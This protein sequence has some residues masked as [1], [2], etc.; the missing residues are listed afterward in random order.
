MRGRRWRSWGRGW[1]SGEGEDFGDLEPV[2]TFAW[3]WGFP[4]FIA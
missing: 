2:S 4:D 1:R 3:S